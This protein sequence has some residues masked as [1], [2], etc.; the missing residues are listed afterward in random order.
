MATYIKGVNSYLADIKPFTPDYKFLSAVLDTRTDKYDANFQATNDL[1]NKVVYADLS[2]EDTRD[3]RDQYAETI[4]PQLEQISGLDLSLQQNV[5]SAKGV[6]APFFQDDL[7]VKDIVYTSRYRDEMAYAN[8][9]LDNPNQEQREKYWE[10]GIRKMQYELDDFVNGSTTAALNAQLPKYIEDADLN[11]LATKVLEE[12][13]PPLKMKMDR[14]GTRPNPKFDPNKPISKTNLKEIV[15]TD[16]IITEQNGRLVTGAA[17]NTIKNRLLDDPRVQRAYYADAY[18]KSRDFAAAGMEAGQFTTVEEG[19]DA[20]ANE[21]ITRINAINEKN[22]NDQTQEADRLKEANVRWSN[23]AANTGV[24]PGSTEATAIEDQLSLQERTEQALDG[25]MGMRKDIN[26]PSKSVQGNLNKA[27]N[28]LMNYNIMDDMYKA[29]T[30]F[31]ARDQSYEM[32]ENKFALDEQKY[33]YSLALE[34]ARSENDLNN[35]LA[36]QKQKAI[37]D[38]NLSLAEGN[39]KGN[40]PLAQ[41]L[42]QSTTKFGSA[43]TTSVV[44]EDGKVDSQTDFLQ[45]NRKQFI[46]ADNKLNVDQ[47]E[48]ILKAM[49]VMNPNGNTAA[50]DQTYEIKNPS[51]PTQVLFS[52]NIETLRKLMTDPTVNE[53]TGETVGYKNRT[54]IDNIYASTAQQVEDTIGITMNNPDVTLSDTQRAQYDQIYEKFFGTN[55]LDIQREGITAAV[56]KVNSVVSEN[57]KLMKAEILAGKSGLGSNYEKDLKALFNAGFPD[58]VDEDGSVMSREEYIDLVSAGV[59]AKSITNPD[60]AGYDWGTGDK[61]YLKH[62]T[63]EQREW[64]GNSQVTLNVKQYDSNGDPIMVIDRDAISDDVREIYD[65]LK[66]ATNDAF[67]GKKGNLPSVTFNSVRYGAAEVPSDALSNPSYVHQINP[68]AGITAE[69]SVEMFNLLDQ[70]ESFDNKGQVY[71]MLPGNLDGLDAEELL[72]QNNLAR[73]VHEL[74]ITDLATYLNDD[75]QS[76]SRKIA[77]IATLYYMP[78][79][80][81]A[82]QADK[83]TAGYRIVYDPQWLA[84]KK[85][86]SD[87]SPVGALTASEIRKLQGLDEEDPTAAG[88]SIVFPQAMDSNAKA[89]L[90]SYFSFAETKILNSKNNFYEGKVPDGLVPSTEYRVVKNGTGDYKINYTLNNYIPY[91]PTKQK[92][93]T[94]I[95]LPSQFSKPLSFA[96]GLPGIDRQINQ[97]ID[98]TKQEVRNLN[99]RLVKKD[100]EQYGIKNLILDQVSGQPK[101]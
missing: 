39:I 74:Y 16:F 61:N 69:G 54:L 77:P 99:R 50:L 47:I 57:Y 4:A 83:T 23:Y 89:N 30:D 72:E 18:V 101:Q 52:G 94:G 2:R 5:D 3:R 98:Q 24:I 92:G 85:A 40:D 12:M 31:A 76:R 91:D 37:D 79:F 33:Q 45:L 84:S 42:K 82:D 44:V 65:V 8:R 1:Y 46:T 48:G 22:I 28:L 71:G 87:D 17:L 49:Q 51:D 26:V 35:K 6:F 90:N 38:Y 36:L 66:S 88:I 53:E 60:L 80:G 67:M 9:L 43:E 58:I 11:E 19:Q 59:S 96:K 81:P 32:R 21:T 15:N 56:E 93:T 95:Y 100:K 41:K 64:T 63:V 20:F 62:K 27:Y 86:G 55:G 78:V 70:L 10:T 73:R 14:F 34:R 75:K 68:L 97:F 25:Y 7:T 13:D 29:A